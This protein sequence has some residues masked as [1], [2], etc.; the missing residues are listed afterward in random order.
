MLAVGRLPLRRRTAVAV[1]VG[2]IVGAVALALFPPPASAASTTLHV[3]SGPASVT[4]AGGAEAPAT[5][6]EL[7]GAGDGVSTGPDGYALLAFVDGSTLS[8]EPGTS[9]TVTEASVRPS[10]TEVRLLQALGRTWSSVRRLVSPTSRYEILTPSV[11]ASVRGTAFEVAVQSDGTT[12]VRAEDGTVSVANALGSVIVGPG[13]QTTVAPSSAPPPPVAP[14][15]TT[16]RVVEIG[17]SA[18]VLVDAFGRACGRH[19]NGT[20]QQIPGCVVREGSIEIAGAADATLTIASTSTTADVVERV[21]SPDGPTV[22]VRRLERNAS[23]AGSRLVLPKATAAP[24]NVTL[25]LVGEV[26]VRVDLTTPTT[27]APASET[28][29]PTPSAFVPAVTLPPLPT[30][31]PLAT[32]SAELSPTPSPTPEPTEPTASPTPLLTLPP[33]ELSPTPSPTPEPTAEPTASP[34]PTPLLTLPPIELS[35]TP[36]PTPEPTASPTP[37]A[38]GTA[39]PSPTPLLPLPSVELSPAPTP[40]PEPTS[41][42]VSEPEPSPTPEPSPSETSE[43]T[44][45]PTP[46]PTPTPTP[47]PEVLGIPIPVC[48]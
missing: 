41:S 39:T 4:R 6:G 23:D 38:S 26:P 28:S 12:R 25:P 36:S 8:L 34:S 45:S 20:V 2:A 7:V 27:P 17:D 40:T 18:V 44:P 16:K 5:D 35:P 32:P 22:A 1:L 19:A 15:P 33:L 43:P 42:P 21:V 11:T 37:S 10:G 24:L 48:L 30:F 9:L 14:P 29:T 47:C 31:A 46:K 3:L 13:T